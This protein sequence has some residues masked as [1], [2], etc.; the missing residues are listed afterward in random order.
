MGCLARLAAIHAPTL[1]PGVL[2]GEDA[3]LGVL[4]EHLK[5]SKTPH[6]VIVDTTASAYI[7]QLYKRWMAQVRWCACLG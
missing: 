1:V 3:S 2:Q 6:K 7:P 5:A 4:T